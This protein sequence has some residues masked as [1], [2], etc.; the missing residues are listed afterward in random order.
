MWPKSASAD[1]YTG[2]VAKLEATSPSKGQGSAQEE[3][4]EACSNEDEEERM[5]KMVDIAQTE[6]QRCIDKDESNQTP[7]G[8]IR[9]SQ[10]AANSKWRD[11]MRAW[12][13]VN[14]LLTFRQVV[15]KYPRQKP[16]KEDVNES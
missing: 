16:F 4:Q 10:D 14:P 1:P 2:I 15:E 12:E 7:D 13:T 6:I 11:F 5:Q 8:K 9:K 3:M